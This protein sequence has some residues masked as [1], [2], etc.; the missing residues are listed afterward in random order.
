M[1]ASPGGWLVTTARNRAIDR[2]RRDRTLTA[3][4]RL[5]DLP[6]IVEEEMEE[7]ACP[8]ERLELIFTCCHPAL[9]TGAQVA[10]TLR[11]LRPRPAPPTSVRWRSRTP[12]PSGGFSHAA[13]P[14][15][16]R[17][18]WQVPL[19]FRGLTARLRSRDRRRSER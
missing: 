13:S 4:Y 1:P 9:A 19:R 18:H 15:S 11:A 12:I 6:E 14:G 5:L 2:I 10:L 7:T 3:K 8:D 16:S 17:R